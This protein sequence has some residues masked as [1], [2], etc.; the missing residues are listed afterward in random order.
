MAFWYG[1]KDG[2]EW[3]TKLM[4]KC[5]KGE[6]RLRGRNT[7][8][9]KV[10]DHAFAIRYHNTDVVV[11]HDD[12]SYTLNH[13][14]YKTVT[15]KAR[16]NEYSSARLSQR[17]FVWY[18][19]GKEFVNNCRIDSNGKVIDNLERYHDEIG[20]KGKRY[21]SYSLLGSHSDNL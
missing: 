15:T 13:G 17:Q 2:F 19:D 7:I 18:L 6:K 12:G 10:D 11:I 21:G 9:Y 20:Y 4:A 8:L 3:A 16:I 5:R 14:G 1:N